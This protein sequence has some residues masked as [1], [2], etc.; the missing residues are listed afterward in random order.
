MLG[1]LIKDSEYVIFFTHPYLINVNCK[2]DQLK[3]VSE[4]V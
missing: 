1:E 2:N 3:R 4:L